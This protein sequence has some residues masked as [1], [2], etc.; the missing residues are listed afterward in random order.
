M[1]LLLVIIG[2]ISITT[3][4]FIQIILKSVKKKDPTK[5]KSIP[6]K[7]PASQQKE[8]DKLYVNK[9]IKTFQL[10]GI[11][12]QNLSKSM[13]GKFIGYAKT[14]DNIYDQY[15]VAVYKNPQTHIGYVPIGN[16]T[17]Q[18]SLKEWHNGKTFAWG[19]CD[20]WEYEKEWKG[21]VHMLV[22]LDADV[23]TIV[24]EIV[25]TQE[26]IDHL[27]KDLPVGDKMEML[28]TVYSVNERKKTIDQYFSYNHPAGDWGG[29]FTQPFNFKIVFPKTFI[30][31][32]SKELEIVKDWQ[33][34]I[35]F[36][37]YTF[38]VDELNEKMKNSTLKRIQL[39]KDRIN[40]IKY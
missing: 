37:K 32:L 15:A 4:V 6:I 26:M 28:E 35:K 31:A 36:E 38:L 39:A 10:K 3:I 9:G 23:I 11:E 14:E 30:P 20:Y 17:L 5:S 8:E 25:S 19:T 21:Y 29:V 27:D 13:S 18:N 22:G 24:K 33:N 1:I 40:A 16:K 2:F 12:Y 7:G 34:L